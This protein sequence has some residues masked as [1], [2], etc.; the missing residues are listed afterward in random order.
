MKW[1]QCWQLEAIGDSLWGSVVAWLT[2]HIALSWP[3]GVSPR[4]ALLFGR[5]CKSN[6]VFTVRAD[7]D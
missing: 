3:V 7:P 4:L 5:K 1:M 6:Q 2:E